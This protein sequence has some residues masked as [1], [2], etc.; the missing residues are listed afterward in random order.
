MIKMLLFCEII[1]FSQSQKFAVGTGQD[2]P[3]E[4]LEQSLKFPWQGL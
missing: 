1:L 2:F 4:H 3:F